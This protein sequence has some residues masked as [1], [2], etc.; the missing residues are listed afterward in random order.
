MKTLRVLKE[1]IVGMLAGVSVMGLVMASMAI[2]LAAA[3]GCDRTT[4]VAC[5]SQCQ[6]S[7]QPP[8]PCKQRCQTQDLPEGA[9]HTAG[10]DSTSTSTTSN[11]T[12]TVHT[13]N[14]SGYGLAPEDLRA[15]P[16]RPCSQPKAQVATCPPDLGSD[17]A[18]LGYTTG[19]YRGNTYV[20]SNP[21][22]PFHAGE[23]YQHHQVRCPPA[24]TFGQTTG[25]RVV[26]P[27]APSA[28]ALQG[29][30]PR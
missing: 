2:G 20:W 27:G 18:A 12:E 6:E 28:A 1:I 16:T 3:M 23:N 11:G 17:D 10:F 26:V 19:N 15:E 22:R 7:R 21:V 13:W 14:A 9:W 29:Q 5:Q 24:G 30:I 8:E 4:Q 25:L